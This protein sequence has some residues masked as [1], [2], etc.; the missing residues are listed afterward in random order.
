MHDWLISQIS[1][2]TEP[3]TDLI[4]AFGVRLA[5]WVIDLQISSTVYIKT[6]DPMFNISEANNADC[7][8][9]PPLM[10]DL[11]KNYGL[12]DVNELSSFFSQYF[13]QGVSSSTVDGQ[14]FAHD[15]L[16][17]A[18]LDWEWAGVRSPAHDPGTFLSSCRVQMIVDPSN[19]S[20]LCFMNAFM[21]TYRDSASQH[22]AKSSCCSGRDLSLVAQLKKAICAVIDVVWSQKVVKKPRPVRLTTT[23]LNFNTHSRSNSTSSIGSPHNI[24]TP[25]SSTPSRWGNDIWPGNSP[26][27]NAAEHIGSIIKDEVEQ[28]MLSET[29]HNRYS[30]DTL[31][32]HIV[33]V[34]TDVEENTELF[35]SL[36]CSY[37]SR[38]R[39]LKSANDRHTDY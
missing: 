28:K 15:D 5:N 33:D 31:E 7:I 22:K 36:L 20:L 8:E 21:D 25:I 29:G 10:E 34:L 26:D 16:T 23:W 9:T 30:K 35:E 2:L 3:I 19:E 24:F 11:R 1:S 14:V 4:H 12:Y 18:I 6:L 39:A 13:Q 38:T 27:L 17:L 32:R 37:P